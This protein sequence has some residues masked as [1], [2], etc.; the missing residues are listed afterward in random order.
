MESQP[1]NSFYSITPDVIL[2][3]V[4]TVGRRSTGRWMALNSI[5]NRVFDVEMD[6]SE[7]LIIKFYRPGRWTE[8]AIKD[9][10]DFIKDL[11]EA[12]IP[13]A[14]PL[15]LPHGSTV[16]VT[17]DQVYF[18]VFP[19]KRGRSPQELESN[20]L[21]WLGRFIA[22]MHVV[23]EKR[24]AQHRLRLSVDHHIRTTLKIL[25]EGQ[26]LAPEIK[27]QYA[28][29]A[30]T[31]A[32]KIE[33][34]LA[35]QPV[36]RIH[37]DCHLGNLL[38]N[39]DGFF[40]VD[41]DDMMNGPALQDLWLLVN[42]AGDEAQRFWQDLLDGYRQFREIGDVDFK[43]IEGL[44]AMRIVHYSGWIARRWDD[45]SFPRL[46]PDFGSFKYWSQEMEALERIRRQ[47]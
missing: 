24:Q 1:K 14:A 18:S 30:E 2:T 26:W 4:E 37:G 34:L 36:F 16:G 10:H 41:F 6:D 9:E 11:E 47:L 7:R 32:E 43:L 17:N 42:R 46:F 19:K 12:E 28:D 25:K 35:K 29:C 23:G 39:Q 45:P 22:R 13:V 15:L 44:R 8:D 3:S 27:T 20:Q 38:S 33:P 40:F 21:Q 31:I 5:E